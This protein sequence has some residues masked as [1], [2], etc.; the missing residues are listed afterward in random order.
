LFILAQRDIKVRYRQ[1]VIGAAWA[2][3]QP[4]VTMLIFSGLF[5]LLGKQPVSGGVPYAVT[6]FCGLLPWQFFASGLTQASGSLVNYRHVVTKVYFPR[7]LMPMASILCALVDFAIAFV[8]LVGL[9]LAFRV[10]VSWEVVTLPLFVLLALL[11][12]LGASLWLSALNSLYRDFTYVVPFIIQIGFFLSPVVYETRSLIPERWR[13]LYG[14]NPLVVVI[15]GFRWALLRETAP[16][17]D[18]LLVSLAA[19]ALLLV[20]GL[21]YFS[22][23]ERTLADRI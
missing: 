19:V 23:V 10:G 13:L 7:M 6:A 8:V 20:S 2:V 16:A 17:V 14:L 9:M 12:T 4:V 21:L 3:L 15:E 18:V 5:S 11:T 22:R 1:A